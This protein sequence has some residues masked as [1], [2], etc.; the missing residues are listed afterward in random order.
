MR[1]REFLARTAALAGA[2]GLATALP[3]D[4]LISQAARL[5]QSAALPTPRNMPIDTFV[6][7]MMENRS[8][9][10]YFGWRA[11]ADGKNAG[12][13]YPD[14]QGHLHSTHPL[15]PD[16]QGC[17]F[18]DPDHSWEGGRTQFDNGK[19]D[20]FRRG[21]NDDYALGYY[22]K[23]EVAF[24]HPLARAFTLY[25]R[26]FC[27]LLGPTWPNREYMH[28]AQSGGNK[29]KASTGGRRSGTGSWPAG[30]RAPTTRPTSRSSPSSEAAIGTS[31]RR[32]PSTTPTRRPETCLTSPSSIPPSW[33]AAAETASPGTSIRTATSGSA[34]RSCPRSSTRSWSRRSSSAARCSS[35]TT[36][37]AGSSTTSAPGW[38][39]T[40]GRTGT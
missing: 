37:G 29:Q 13:K 40:T 25:D 35:T 24:L 31:P 16:Y 20:G 1:R 4:G 38:F 19:L 3:A 23:G 9:D 21:D 15:A 18:A 8:F 30:S 17:G 2:A 12:L 32:F 5:Q 39:R 6:V 26:Y 11:D 33:M 7:L 27:S 14:D 22:R 28:S 36:S 10:H 34:R